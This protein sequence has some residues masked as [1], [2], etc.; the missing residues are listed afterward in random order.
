MADYYL[1]D[2]SRLNGQPKRTI[3]EYVESQGILVPRRFDSLKDALVSGKPIM[4]RS[5]HPRE[6]D[7]FSGVFDSCSWDSFMSYCVGE[8][9]R[10]RGVQDAAELKNVIMHSEDTRKSGMLRGHVASQYC[11]ILGLD[12]QSELAK[13]SFSF[14]EKL[15]GLNRTV[16]ADSSIRGRWHIQTM[17][18]IPKDEKSWF[19]NYSIFENGQ[20]NP[21]LS[22]GWNYVFNE[23][24]RSLI[25][26]Y[27]T[28][29]HIERFDPNNCPVMEFQ[30]IG[31]KHYFLQYHVG[32]DFKECDF[33]L[34]RPPAEGEAE[35]LFVRG[36]TPK[37]GIAGRVN[38]YYGWEMTRSR[39]AAAKNMKKVFEAGEFGSFDAHWNLGFAQAMY[40]KRKVNVI[41]QSYVDDVAW[42]L[43]KVVGGHY[44][45]G[46]MFGPKMSIAV[47]RG[48]FAGDDKKGAEERETTR[49]AKIARE[50]EESVGIDMYFIS[51]G[52]RGYYKRL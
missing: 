48:L 13:L 16:I 30:T 33:V 14:W 21:R 3:A 5:E 25:E 46:K 45:N 15:Y 2:K 1:E 36:H 39:K 49:L 7:E 12:C 29:R 41:A 17:L 18:D 52:R 32:R 44:Q 35:S 34:E 10:K 40:P 47:N 23:D 31:D 4:F 24:T 38:L 27:E 6:Y 42:E 50:T 43:M 37:E 11:N 28:I 22:K 9:R 8:R 19:Y 20:T 51:D 26:L